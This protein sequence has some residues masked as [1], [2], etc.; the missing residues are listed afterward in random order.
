MVVLGGGG[1]RLRL[2]PC[3]VLLHGATKVVMVVVMLGDT[4][5]SGC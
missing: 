3:H 2:G 5:A 4:A 1:S